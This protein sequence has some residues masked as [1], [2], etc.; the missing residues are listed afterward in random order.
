MYAK[1]N[2]KAFKSIFNLFKMLAEVISLKFYQ[3][4]KALLAPRVSGKRPKELFSSSVNKNLTKGRVPNL[5][6]R[7][8]TQ[9]T[10]ILKTSKNIINIVCHNVLLS[11][12]QC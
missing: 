9:P 8:S 4:N 6:K 2:S 1:V 5:K 3:T 10:L 12:C 11:H 7:E